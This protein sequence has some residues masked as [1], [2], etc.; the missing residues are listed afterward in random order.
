MKIVQQTSYTP[1]MI[2]SDT[3]IFN[4]KLESHIYLIGKERVLCDTH[5]HHQDI[6]ASENSLEEDFHGRFKTN[7]W[8]Y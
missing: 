5:H 3:V 2:V 7:L 8:L 1:G 4:I 6:I